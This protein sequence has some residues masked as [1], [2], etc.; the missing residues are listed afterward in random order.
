MEVV[1]EKAL[2]TVDSS[3][4]TMEKTE[5]AFRHESDDAA[6]VSFKSVTVSSEKLILTTRL[7][8][9]PS[10]SIDGSPVTQP[11]R[12]LEW[13]LSNPS[14]DPLEVLV[15]SNE[16]VFM[17]RGRMRDE[18]FND[19]VFELSLLQCSFANISVDS[20]N[21]AIVIE[22][23]GYSSILESAVVVLSLG[24]DSA[25][26]QSMFMRSKLFFKED[27]QRKVCLDSIQHIRAKIEY[28]SLSSKDQEEYKFFFESTST[29]EEVSGLDGP[30]K[31]RDRSFFANGWNAWSFCGA[32][33]Q[34]SLLPLYDM[35]DSFVKSFHDG[36]PA[37]KFNRMRNKGSKDWIASD[38]FT[39]VADRRTRAGL[40]IGFLSQKQQFGCI[41][42][43]E[44]Y[45]T[46]SVYTAHDG[47]QIDSKSR[48]IETD[49]LCVQ[50][51]PVLAVDPLANYMHL[52][53]LMN[54]AQAKVNLPSCDYENTLLQLAE[55][56]SSVKPVSIS[57]H[58]VLNP[59]IP[60]GW[61]SW[62]HF[63][64]DITETCLNQNIEELRDLA[65]PGSQNESTT[66]M[67][68]KEFRTINLFQVDD[69]YQTAWGDWANLKKREFPS[70]S[71]RPLVD[72]IQA[73][74]LVPGIWM[75]PFACD[76]HSK[77]ASKYPSW[78]LRNRYNQPANSASCGKW[79]Y[80][81]DVTNI[82]VQ[83]HIR[84]SIRHVIRD[85]GFRY[86]KLDFLY[87]GILSAKSGSLLN[88]SLTG[89]QAMQLGMT[90]IA[91][92]VA[93]VEGDQVIPIL[94]CGAPIGSVIGHVHLNRIS[95][96]AGLTW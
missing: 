85:W 64:D 1:P 57:E 33:L 80:G 59:A 94:G 54:G 76:K 79:F 38:M 46:F 31:I 26:S 72:K 9:R 5:S 17:V 48:C 50:V 28:E 15:S 22:L 3:T 49:W 78:I 37:L 87:A 19:Q 51:C 71:L 82:E 55:L 62:Y 47:A 53:G 84:N 89:A 56:S 77:I 41:T 40:V 14:S 36:G 96:D 24:G 34:G 11:I 21:R 35:P 88:T 20:R 30:H 27:L 63:F 29:M 92:A 39:V 44:D 18:R 68:T 74:G 86:L 91:Q 4:T 45:E 2:A 12:N 42:S 23:K 81:L 95:A 32:V 10:P 8:I 69:G 73:T 70:A 83:G 93:D 58:P 61:C 6:E 75:A 90:V 60:V 25:T 7:D 67:N 13:T 43:D 16:S 65:V 52:S 66:S